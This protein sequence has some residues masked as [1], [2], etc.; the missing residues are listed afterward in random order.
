[1]ENSLKP[2][3]FGYLRVSTD[4]QDVES[5]K[6]GLL[7]YANRMGF[8][9]V[10]IVSETVSRTVPWVERE[11]GKLLQMTKP[12]DVILTP[13][14]TRLASKPGQVFT[15]LEEAAGKGVVIHIT[16]T[17]TVMDGSMQSQIWASVFSMASLIE[18]S[19]IRERTKE[20]C[21]VPGKKVRR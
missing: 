5:Q 4:V 8:A 1:M 3:Y 20:G 7:E 12:G 16:K 15:F 11:L 10:K 18:V 19:F 2:A 9:P 14:F 13:E 21:S 17:G 6:L